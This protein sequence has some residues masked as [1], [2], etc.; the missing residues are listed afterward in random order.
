[1]EVHTIVLPRSTLDVGVAER[2]WKKGG[3]RYAGAAALEPDVLVTESSAEHFAGRD[4]VLEAPSSLPLVTITV[5]SAD[6]SAPG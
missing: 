5:R 2:T 1:L 6:L 4:P 3:R